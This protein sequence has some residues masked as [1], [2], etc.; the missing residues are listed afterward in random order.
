MK[1]NNF[2]LTERYLMG[3]LSAEESA[4]F[5]KLMETDTE[6]KAELNLR[7]EIHEAILESDIMNL[8]H[9]MSE[10]MNK[11]QKPVFIKNPFLWSATAAVFIL[12]MIINTLFISSPADRSDIFKKYYKAYPSVY[13]SRSSQKQSRDQQCLRIAFE[14][15]D[16]PDFES[17]GLLFK[18]IWFKDSTNNM[19]KFYLSI[20]LI[21]Q[22]KM[23]EAEKY[24]NEL[25][26][27]KQHLFYE[28]SVWYLALVYLNNNK[29]DEAE[30]LLNKIIS[31]NL[32]N[33]TRAKQILKSLN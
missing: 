24:L 18:E 33:K 14:Q 1:R 31:E 16:K 28:Q 6:L 10:I 8:R 7:K 19:A 13:S 15:Y 30:R 3:D 21:E 17:A 22:N 5:E 25:T 23:N 11:K 4:A 2:D 26:L 20:A 29:P 9:T 32:S 12:A 27:N